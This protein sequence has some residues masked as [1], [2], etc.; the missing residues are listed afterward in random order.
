LADE[1]QSE[2]AQ[3][4]RRRLHARLAGWF[5]SHAFDGD[6][7]LIPDAR[8]AEEVP[9]Q[10][11]KA[12]DWPHLKACLTRKDMFE[13]LYANRSNEELLSYWLDLEREANADITKDY[14]NAWSAWGIDEQAEEAGNI[15]GKLQGFLRD[16]GR[17][18]AF[19]ERMA[20]LSLAIAE[21][22]QGPE[23]PDTGERLNN[24]AILLQA[25]G[26]YVAAE[27][28]YRRALAIAEKA[29]G[30]EHPSTGAS[31]DN[32]AL[33]LKAK[34]QY[35]AA[36]PLNR[37]AL[38]I[39]EKAQGPEHPET[40]IRLNN[41]AGLLQVKGDYDAAEPLYRRALAIA[42]RVQGPEHPDVTNRLYGLGNVLVALGRLNEAEQ[43][44]RREIDI[45]K[46]HDGPTSSGLGISLYNLAKVLADRGRLDD[47]EPLFRREIDIV[48]AEEGDE[49]TSL[50]ASYRNLGSRLRDAG[51]L[52]AAEAEL[53]KAIAFAGKLGIAEPYRELAELRVLQH[54]RPEAIDLLRQGLS[55]ARAA[56]EPNAEFINCLETRLSE[57]Q[58]T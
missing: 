56:S 16:A 50:E 10:W 31:L 57:L 32:L 39:A 37:R 6:G 41:L 11:C 18:K 15:A 5:E 28:L 8:A 2:G 26:D 54:R 1:S 36:E 48:R 9:Y 47:A 49:S 52:D 17:Y 19:T 38:A 33:L 4:L 27:P 35:E 40:G 46:A 20:R 30:P 43:L 44:L 45:V 23:H 58:G 53:E 13:A 29:L 22:A 24:L 3:D 12:G 34:G 51:R 55:I 21:K 42:E 25:K 7:G 14:E